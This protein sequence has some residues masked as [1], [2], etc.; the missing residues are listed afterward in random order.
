MG[1]ERAASRPISTGGPARRLPCRDGSTGYGW[2][3]AHCVIHPRERLR[4]ALATGAIPAVLLPVFVQW[5]LRC[6]EADNGNFIRGTAMIS[7]AAAQQRAIVLK[8]EGEA[9]L[10]WGGLDFPDRFSE[11]HF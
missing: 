9:T 11:G 8:H 3:W 1:Q 7:F 2:W 10:R 4:S 6:G 5:L